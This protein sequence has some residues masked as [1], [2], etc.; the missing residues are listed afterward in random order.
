MPAVSSFTAIVRFHKILP[1]LNQNKFD[2]ICQIT[3]APSC[4]APLKCKENKYLMRRFKNSCIAA[5]LVLAFVLSVCGC[6]SKN[7][8]IDTAKSVCATFCEDVRSGDVSK[9]MAYFNDPSVTEA[10]LTEMITFEDPNIEQGEYYETLRESLTY[11]L[12]EPVYDSKAKTATVVT[13][14]CIGNYNSESAKAAKDLQEFKSAISLDPKMLAVTLTVDFSGETP[15]LVNPMDAIKTVYEFTTYESNIMPGLLSDYYADGDLILAPKGKYNN[16]DTIGVRINFSEELMKYRFIPGVIYSV[17]KGEDAVYTS[18]PIPLEENSIRLDITADMV[19]KAFVNSDGFFVDGSYKI[20]VFDEHSKDIATFECTVENEIRENDVLSFENHKKDYYLSNLVFDIQDDDLMSHSFVF[21]SGWW[22]YDGTSV[23]KSAF[24]SNTK[25]LGFSL[26]VSKD[27]ESEV[28]Y[29]FY[30]S[31]E[32]DF[33]S[34]E[35]Q[36]PVYQSS[37]KPTVYE[38]QACYDLDYTP[39]D[40]LEPGFY[41]LA[42]YSDSTKKH[43]LCTAACI[44]VEETSG[45][46][47]N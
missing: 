28:Y 7:K 25:T 43:I 3:V 30:Y 36:K 15:I 41:G 14:W 29:E 1:D 22:D 10:V 37:C 9:L 6:G 33:G 38:D 44:V 35:E 31:S 27:N 5:V 42:V 26:A 24:A 45:D 18:N 20:F 23:G 47:T 21:N 39:K 4:K 12:E 16:T 32:S 13:I 2:I 34:M 19:D 46:V 17:V 11:G 40:A 8:S